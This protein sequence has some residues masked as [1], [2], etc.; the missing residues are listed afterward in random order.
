MEDVL[1]IVSI[2]GWIGS[3]ILMAITLS[4]LREE[5]GFVMALL[6]FFIPLGAYIWGWIKLKPLQEGYPNHKIYMVTWTV[7][8]AAL[9][10]PM[11]ILY[12]GI[13]SA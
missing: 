5:N 7:F 4:T 6:G 12:L 8:I 13:N 9:F 1:V 11:F 2:A 3:L 10:L